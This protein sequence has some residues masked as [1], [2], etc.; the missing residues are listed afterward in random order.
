MAEIDRRE[1]L[2]QTGSATGGMAA[3]LLASALVTAENAAHAGAGPALRAER[4]VAVICSPADAVASSAP[5]QRAIGKL[6]ETLTARGVPVRRCERRD[7]AKPGEL[8]L[9]AAGYA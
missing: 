2:T 1:F 3:G 4:G 9:V 5:V 7:Q 6:A 8:C